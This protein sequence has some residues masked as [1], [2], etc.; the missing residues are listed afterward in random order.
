MKTTLLL[1]LLPFYIFAQTDSTQIKLQEYKDLFIKGLIN[2]QEYEMLKAKQ[3]GLTTTEGVKSTSPFAD[4]TYTQTFVTKYKSNIFGG[5]TLLPIGVGTAISAIAFYNLT[6]NRVDRNGNDI[7]IL[8]TAVLGVVGV[9]ATVTGIVCLSIG[10]RQREVYRNAKLNVA[11][12][13]TPGNT[14]LYLNF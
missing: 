4:S 9:A 2:A 12:N 11:I 7:R 5:A 10:L 13:V 14:G 6:P 1:L 3:L 8:P